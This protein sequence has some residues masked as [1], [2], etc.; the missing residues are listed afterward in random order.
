M[1][2]LDKINLLVGSQ[3]ELLGQILS[4]DWV[5]FDCF[6]DYKIVFVNEKLNKSIIAKIHYTDQDCIEVIDSIWVYNGIYSEKQKTSISSEDLIIH[7]NSLLNQKQTIGYTC[8]DCG[9][10]FSKNQP[11]LC[12]FCNS[13]HIVPFEL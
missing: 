3:S 6:N 5:L 4:E 1:K 11:Y 9:E 8:V 2:N 10:A 7:A 13:K 12:T